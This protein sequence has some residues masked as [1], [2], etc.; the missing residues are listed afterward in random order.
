MLDKSATYMRAGGVG[1]HSSPTPATIHHN[2]PK[3]SPLCK[4]A[5][6][7]P[8]TLG[9]C[10][11]FR[12]LAFMQLIPAYNFQ[13]KNLLIGQSIDCKPLG[14]IV[15][16]Q[17]AH[18]LTRTH[19]NSD[20]VQK[21]QVLLN[22]RRCQNRVPL[23]FWMLF[24]LQGTGRFQMHCPLA[25]IFISLLLLLTHPSLSLN[26]M[27]IFSAYKP[28][29]HSNLDSLTELQCCP[30]QLSNADPLDSKKGFL[31]RKPIRKRKQKQ[32]LVNATGS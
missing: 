5:S 23:V 29:A 32:R 14:T 21:Q 26:L 22:F 7:F 18:L 10:I 11:N 13:S 17:N 9:N 3:T 15:P 24:Y 8:P 25:E 27:P 4:Q 30:L 16:L 19:F 20:K 2:E 1:K 28:Q 12:H 31:N 6:F